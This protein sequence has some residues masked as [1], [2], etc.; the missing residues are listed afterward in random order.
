MLLSCNNW[1]SNVSDILLQSFTIQLSAAK[2]K[3]ISVMWC[4]KTCCIL[5][6]AS[7]IWINALG[8]HGTRLFCCSQENQSAGPSCYLLWTAQKW[9]ELFNIQ[10]WYALH[11]VNLLLQLVCHYLPSTAQLHFNGFERVVVISYF[12]FFT[13][14]CISTCSNGDGKHTACWHNNVSLKSN[15]GKVCRVVYWGKKHNSVVMSQ[16]KRQQKSW[17][18]WER[19]SEQLSWDCIFRFHK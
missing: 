8:S 14:K 17:N 1:L 5:L 12:P 4:V 16:Q 15:L 11:L 18:V 2:Q 6:L 7:D 9:R 19:E 3:S 13:L 10:S